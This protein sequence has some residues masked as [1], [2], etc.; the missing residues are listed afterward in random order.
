VDLARLLD[1]AALDR[2]LAARSFRAFAEAAFS[3]VEPGVTFL[4]NWHIDAICDHMEAVFRNDIKDLVINVPPGSMKSLLVCTLYPAWAWT[5]DPGRRG[6]YASYAADLANRDSLR[7][8]QLIESPWYQARWGEAAT[9]PEWRKVVHNHDQWAVQRFSNAA[10]GFRMATTVAGRL[11]G[12]HGHDLVVDDP[13]KPDECTDLALDKAATWWTKGMV[14]RRLPGA[15]RIVIMQRL[16]ERDLAGISIDAGFNALVVP[17]RS[18]KTLRTRTPLRVVDP[19]TEIDQP[20][21]PARWTEQELIELEADLGPR[22]VAAQLQQRPAPAEG[23]IFTHSMVRYYKAHP[24]LRRMRVIL[25]VDANFKATSQGSYAV[26]QTWGSIGGDQYLLDQVRERFAFSDLLEAVRRMAAKWSTASTILI[27]DKA[28]GPAIISVLEKELS[29]VIPCEP[30]GDKVQRAHA[31]EP[32]WAAGN[33]HLPDPS[34]APWIEDFVLELLSFPVARHDDQVDAMSQALA[35]L[36]RRNMDKFI[37][38][39]NKV[40]KRA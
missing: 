23:A 18:E 27:E 16:H 11:V 20:L 9:A 40:G 17:M 30:H 21:W 10:A 3:Q 12:Y 1:L 35:Y 5:Q 2:E 33:V 38:A 31:V 6:I 19:R 28:N 37:A 34:I 25:S 14:T 24:A 29:G 7:C 8:R 13:I 32:M 39:M 4:P 36:K 22:Q 26:I 15:H